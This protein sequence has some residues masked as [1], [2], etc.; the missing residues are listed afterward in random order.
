MVGHS[1]P[2]QFAGEGGGVVINQV[3]QQQ[4]LLHRAEGLGPGHLRIPLQVAE[5]ADDRGEDCLGVNIFDVKSCGG[6][7]H[8]PLPSG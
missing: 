7:D 2:V 8:G 3:P 1:Q 5:L 6:V 4:D